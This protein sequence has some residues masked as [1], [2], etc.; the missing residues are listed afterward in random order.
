MSAGQSLLEA[1]RGFA[2]DLDGVVWRGGEIIDGA[3]DALRAILN[4]GKPFLLLT[5]NGSYSGESVATK[6]QRCDLNIRP[7][8]VLSSTMV[9]V[10]W[11]EDNH[12]AG[13]AAFVL[14]VSE[15][16]DQLEKLVQLKPIEIGVSADIVVVARWTDLTYEGLAAVA[17]ALRAGAIF[18]TLNNDPVMP[19]ENGLV[20]GTGTV[21]AALQAA[22]GKA[23]IVLGKPETPMMS[24]GASILGTEGILMVGDRPESDI[25]GARRIGW[26]AALVMSGVSGPESVMEP[27][28]DYLLDSLGDIVS[29]APRRFAEPDTT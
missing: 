25:L 16:A 4:S 26:D 18:L 9:A 7:D 20:P 6:L 1:Y 15:V 17:D 2:I 3:V 14:G 28:P 24:A 10:K 23:P 29:P 27:A 11:I 21:V 19:V 8:Q 12:F 5:N 22:S 13:K